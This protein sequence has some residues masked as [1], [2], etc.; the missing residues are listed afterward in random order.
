MVENYSSH[1][2]AVWK[3]VVPIVCMGILIACVS[4]YQVHAVSEE[5]RRGQHHRLEWRWHVCVLGIE[6][7][8]SVQTANAVK[9]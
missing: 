6:P 4:V 1:M 7:R 5:A 2:R 9:H 3:L 8:S